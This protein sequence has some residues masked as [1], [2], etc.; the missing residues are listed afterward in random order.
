MHL[1]DTGSTVN[2]CSRVL[3]LSFCLLFC[4]HCSDIMTSGIA[5]SVAIRQNNRT[6]VH[7]QQQST[8]Q[9]HFSPTKQQR[10]SV[11][12]CTPRQWGS[13][14]GNQQFWVLI[15]ISLKRRKL[16]KQLSTTKAYNAKRENF[17][18]SHAKRATCYPS[19]LS[20]MTIVTTTAHTQWWGEWEKSKE[21]KN[22]KQKTAKKWSNK[23]RYTNTHIHIFA[24]T[25]THKHSNK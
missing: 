7:H 17:S 11:H 1:N 2:Q 16:H 25:F 18:S 23:H 9:P 24:N 13:K 20:L 22:R 5:K 10:K 15:L 12:C 3:L 21:L 8:S 6:Y 14:V 4:P 19:T